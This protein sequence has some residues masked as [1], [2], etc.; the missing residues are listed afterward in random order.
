M[1]LHRGDKVHIESACPEN[2]LQVM[3]MAELKSHLAMINVTVMAEP[4]PEAKRIF[5][6]RGWD[7]ASDREVSG[8]SEDGVQI[9]TLDERTLLLSGMTHRGVLNAT[10]VFL[11]DFLGFLWFNPADTHVPEKICWDFSK[12]SFRHD[13]SFPLR[14]IGVAGAL[15]NSWCARKRLNLFIDRTMPDD[16]RLQDC[17][18]FAGKHC[19]NVY[20]LLSL[21][22]FGD[23]E[24]SEE[25]FENKELIREL[26]EV[27]P[28]Y[29]ALIDG[30]REPY[31]KG[32]ANGD[33]SDQ[34]GNISLTN[35]EV[36]RVLVK[37]GLRLLRHYPAARCISLSLRDNYDY[38]E[39][40][41]AAPG[42]ITAALLRLVNDF[43]S[44][45][46]LTYP[47]VRVD[48]LA[49][50]GTQRPPAEGKFHPNVRVR[51]CP[52]RVSQYHAF[53]ESEHNLIG[54]LNYETPPSMAQPVRQLEQWTRL[55]TQVVVWYYTLNVPYFH[56]QPSLR[57]H[58]RTFRLL[59]S[60]GVKG[61]FIQDNQ[62]MA[63]NGFN[64]LRAH[65]LTKLLWD[66][67]YDEQR[68]IHDFCEV[69][70]GSASRFIIRYIELLHEEKS[71]DW[72]NWTDAEGRSKWASSARERSWDWFQDSPGERFPVP[73]FYTLYHTRP[74]LKP[75]FFRRGWPL[76][77]SAEAAVNG[78][79]LFM[80]RLEEVL[81]SFF[82]GV[83]SYPTGD[84]DLEAVARRWFVPRFRA[85][86]Q[87]YSGK[88]FHGLDRV[89]LSWPLHT[90]RS[91]SGKPL[92]SS[93]L[94]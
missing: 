88:E 50:H 62:P 44:E 47:D 49:Y 70:Y 18:T 37:G 32:G 10:Y 45:L 91:E 75:C 89:G 36:P 39:E 58:G 30:S 68:G 82:Y 56:P 7:E 8:L 20:K 87:K 92:E 46:V 22:F 17:V 40:A 66:P 51:Y 24:S 15:D 69:Y 73:H 13:P 2:S 90:V 34:S 67:Q 59:Q 1:I 54:G 61:V 71:W 6:G 41:L 12:V 28:E 21:G 93:V 9:R 83:L 85:I 78:Q 31:R 33:I 43:A 52:I 86:R 76:L 23:R 14:F 29:F 19:H 63:E 74:P 25:P 27:H 79:P 60:L 72:E 16:P 26:Y 11:E 81:M 3:A 5:L 65:L 77:R 38:C 64:D 48:F 35:P 42:G 94:A 84:D 4:E 57:G 80:Q 53:D 55:A